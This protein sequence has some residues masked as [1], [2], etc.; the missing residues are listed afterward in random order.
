MNPTAPLPVLGPTELAILGCLVTVDGLTVAEMGKCLGRTARSI[1]RSVNGLDEK[2]CIAVVN[3][4][5]T[6][7]TKAR[8]WGATTTGHA[9]HE[10]HQQEACDA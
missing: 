4:K 3:Y 2:G 9:A 6:Q 7:G 5:R 1:Q 10:A 8:V